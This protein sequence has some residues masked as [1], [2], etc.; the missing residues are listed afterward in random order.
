MVVDRVPQ[1]VRRGVARRLEFG[2]LPDVGRERRFQLGDRVGE[3]TRARVHAMPT[4]RALPLAAPRPWR[5]IVDRTRWP[6]YHVVAKIGRVPGSPSPRNGVQRPAGAARNC[7]G[8]RHG[9]GAPGPLVPAPPH[10]R[11]CACKQPFD[12][13]QLDPPRVEAQQAVVRVVDPLPEPAERIALGLGRVQVPQPRFGRIVIDPGARTRRRTPALGPGPRTPSETHGFA[14]RCLA[15]NERRK[16]ASQPVGSSH[17]GCTSRP[18]GPA[19]R[20]D[21]RHRAPDRALD[22]A[23]ELRRDLL[24]GCD[25]HPRRRYAI[26]RFSRM[27]F[28]LPKDLADYLVELD[29]F[30]EREIKPLEQENDNIR[31]FDHRREDARTDWDRGGLPERR[32]GRQLLAR[33]AAPR[34]RGRATTAIRSRRSTAARTARTS[35]WP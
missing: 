17:T 26:A 29:D 32:S 31:F 30:I 6:P 23:A 35:A 3:Q 13:P 4:W 34:R 27:D 24:E 21:G 5:P 28:E 10:L 33:G 9:E 2:T 16:V 14:S 8:C 12:R 19:P 1:H 22:P 11:R 7:S 18:H 20:V 15:L 25:V